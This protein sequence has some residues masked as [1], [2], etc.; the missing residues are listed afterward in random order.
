MRPTRRTCLLLALW[1][2]VGL[3]VAIAPELWPVWPILG[4]LLAIALVSDALRLRGDDAIDCERVVS[5]SLP[6]GHESEVALTL[7]W[8][9]PDAI[10]LRVHDHPPAA[11][12]WRA[13][14]QD[15]T[16]EGGGF[17][18]LRYRFRPLARGQHCFGRAEILKRSPTG[19]WARAIRVGEPTEVH[20]YPDFRGALGMSLIATANRTGQV[21]VRK[22]RR[23]GEGMEF[24][25]LRDY[26]EDDSLRQI[27]WKATA[28]YGRPISRDYQ[29]ERDQQVVFLLDC[30]RRMHSRDGELSHFDHA[31][32]ALLLVANAA[33]RQGDSVGLISFAGERRWLAPRKGVGNLNLLLNTIYDLETTTRPSDVLAVAR[34]T[35]RHLRKRSLVILVSNLRDEDSTELEMAL[36]LLRRRHLVLV[37]SLREEALAETLEQDIEH[38][39][40][41]LRNAATHAYLRDRELAHERLR[42]KG[43]L[44][45]DAEARELPARLMNRYLEIKRAGQ[46]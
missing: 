35:L 1:A 2:G 17:A 44:W 19:L 42:G 39:D 8:R 40:E 24:H 28:K 15:V 21:G 5:T 4:S 27:D 30:G 38:F 3:A 22:R 45:L 43:V 29:D 32:N 25:Q 14:P 10:T 31:L 11:S 20:V 16:I 12:E 23:R 13:L 18:T 41:A 46:L 9:G 26:R 37:A 36:R 33:L 6:L 34:D 7:H